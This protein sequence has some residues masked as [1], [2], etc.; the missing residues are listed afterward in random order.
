MKI[1]KKI[2]PEYFEKILSGEKTFEL[3]LADFNCNPG[4]ILV[5][6]EYDSNKKEYTGRK[7]EKQAGYV[8][9]TKDV[10]FWLKGD[11]EKYGYQIIS[12]K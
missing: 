8:F 10:D 5:L 6:R 3:R 4:D 12:L 2:L 1:E 11:I 9:K 7:L